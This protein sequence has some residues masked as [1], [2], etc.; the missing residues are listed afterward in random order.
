MPI[1]ELTFSSSAAIFSRTASIALQNLKGTFRKT[2]QN[3]EIS[4]H[5][6][7]KFRTVSEFAEAF[8]LRDKFWSRMYVV[9]MNFCRRQ[10]LQSDRWINKLRLKWPV[11]FALF[12]PTK[13][14]YL[15]LSFNS[16]FA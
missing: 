5:K 14:T 13:S 8:F 6:M 2:G 10:T 7:D 1:F 12:A 11:Y 3:G 4:D 15:F 9:K 16:I